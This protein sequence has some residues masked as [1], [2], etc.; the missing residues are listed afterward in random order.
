M[1]PDPANPDIRA[2]RSL[3]TTLNNRIGWLK[4]HGKVGCEQLWLGAPHAKEAIAFGLDLLAVV[5]HKRDVSVGFVDPG[6]Q[7]K[8][9][10]DTALHISCAQ[11][12]QHVAVAFGGQVVTGR[13]GIYMACQHNSFGLV[14]LRS[15]NQRITESLYVQVCDVGQRLSDEICQFGLMA[16]LGIDIYQCC[17]QVCCVLL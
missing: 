2:H 5:E 4:E 11:P 10:G 12:K 8:H 3:T 14:E 13:D 15:G 9:D 6:C 7:T 17:G 1:C 16:A